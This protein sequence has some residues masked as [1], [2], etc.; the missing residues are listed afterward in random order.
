MPMRPK[1]V[2]RC[3]NQNNSR[4][5]LHG[6]QDVCLSRFA[7][8]ISNLVHR[9]SI[10]IDAAEEYAS[11]AKAGSRAAVVCIKQGEGSDRF[12]RTF[13]GPGN[14]SRSGAVFARRGQ[15]VLCGSDEG[16]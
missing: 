7:S 16:P 3:A 8:I 13:K 6:K 12:Q 9:T 15:I 11:I 14:Q 5:L 10:D 1:V 2:L 4:S